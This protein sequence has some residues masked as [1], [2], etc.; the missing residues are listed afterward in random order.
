MLTAKLAVF[1]HSTQTAN[2]WINDIAEE[3]ATEDHHF[4][5]RVLRAWLHTL[6][7]RLTI[8]ACAHFAAQLPLVIRGLYYEGWNPSKVPEKYAADMYAERFAL[9][10]G[11]S[12]RDVPKA[13]SVV[14]TVLRRHLTAG[15][16]DK[17]VDQL[18]PTIR[19]LLQQQQPV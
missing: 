8:E 18:P 1:E 14:G 11:I 15:Q 19:V 13:A 16:I 12:A 10:A 7:D 3:F 5:Y 9:T 6:R 17:V 4:A 2:A